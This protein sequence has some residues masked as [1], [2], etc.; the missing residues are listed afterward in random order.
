MKK[1]VKEYYVQYDLNIFLKENNVIWKHTGNSLSYG[2]QGVMNF[3]SSKEVQSKPK[4][5][6]G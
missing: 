2:F 1:R 6:F 3:R 5:L 4:V